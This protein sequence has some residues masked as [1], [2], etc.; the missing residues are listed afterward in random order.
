MKFI[1]GIITVFLFIFG[2]ILNNNATSFHHFGLSNLTVKDS[3]KYKVCKIDSINSYYI[4]YAKQGHV[5]FKIISKIDSI[6]KCKD[7]IV[8]KVYNFQ[9]HSILSVNGRPIIPANQIM[10]LSGWRI[11]QSTII[12]FEGDSIRD[13]YYA[14]N[15]KGLCFIKK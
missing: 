4:I 14:D 5:L 6:E 11:D 2:Y 3:A 8:N 15:I 12:A 9:L 7:L 13:L 10:E 1:T